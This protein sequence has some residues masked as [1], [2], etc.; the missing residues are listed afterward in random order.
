VSS[1]KPDEIDTGVAMEPKALERVSGP[2]PL[3]SVRTPDFG[4]RPPRLLDLPGQRTGPMFGR[5]YFFC[6]MISCRFL[7]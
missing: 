1:T 4:H 2:F 5:R 3:S 6:L 7:Q